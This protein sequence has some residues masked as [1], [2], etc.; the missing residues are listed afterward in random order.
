[1]SKRLE[2]HLHANSLHDN[3]Q[4]AY[5]TG[6]STETALLRVHNDIVAALDN[7]CRAVLVMLDLS[8]AFDVIDHGI[9][10]K[11]L[12]YSYGVTG[13][14]LCWIQ[15]YLSERRQCVAIGSTTS[16]DKVL[17]FGVPQGSVLGPRKY[18]LYSKPIGEICR[19]HNLLYHCYADDTQL[20]M[21]IRPQHSWDT[22]S[23]TLEACL[24]DISDWMSANM[25]KLTKIRQISLFSHQSISRQ[26]LSSS[27]LVHKPLRQSPLC[28]IWAYTLIVQ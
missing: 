21:V 17:G 7:K 14:A 13:D 18:C 9:R 10:F 1:M 19:R 24:V 8:A 2:L 12:D 22:I 3:L 27:Q 5:R 4:S 11:R 15:S 23:H 25:L 20:Y 26:T 16:D 6:H 28:E